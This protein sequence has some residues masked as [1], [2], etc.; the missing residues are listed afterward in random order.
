MKDNFMNALIFSCI[1]GD[2]EVKK[3]KK[4]ALQ[5]KS[6]PTAGVYN[7]CSKYERILYGMQKNRTWVAEF[8]NLFVEYW[9]ERTAQPLFLSGYSC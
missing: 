3:F 9:I 4:P 8:E 7:L 1:L 5:I 6:A 2:M